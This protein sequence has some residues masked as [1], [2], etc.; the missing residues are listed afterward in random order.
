MSKE[1]SATD[2]DQA[3]ERPSRPKP[4]NRISTPYNLVEAD[5][6]KSPGTTKSQFQRSHELAAT[7][8]AKS[9]GAIVAG[10][11][12]D[13]CVDSEPGFANA[14]RRTASVMANRRATEK[15]F[16]SHRKK[17]SSI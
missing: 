6:V 12:G 2:F 15:L 9:Q 8:E 3:S 7:S 5:G 10:K 16:D 11:I 1:K 4:T 13:G 14:A 17:S